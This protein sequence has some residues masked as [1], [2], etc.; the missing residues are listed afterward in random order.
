[1]FEITIYD[2]NDQKIDFMVAYT[3]E[4]AMFAVNAFTPKDGG[5]VIREVR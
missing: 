3:H 2:R 4:D 5:Y 1:M